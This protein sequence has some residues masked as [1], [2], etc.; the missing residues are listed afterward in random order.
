MLCL[1]LIIYVRPLGNCRAL[2]PE[3]SKTADA[4]VGEN[5]DGDE[6]NNPPRSRS[7]T[8]GLDV[9]TRKISQLSIDSWSQT[10]G[11]ISSIRLNSYN[12]LTSLVSNIYDLFLL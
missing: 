9:D 4:G 7:S 6:L 3:K 2:E 10:E 8:E 5:K 1:I 12:A 11:F